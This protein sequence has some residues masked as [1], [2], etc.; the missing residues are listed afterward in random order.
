MAPP[1][2]FGDELKFSRY[3]KIYPD[4]DRPGSYLLYSTK[5]GSLIRLTE[6]LLADAREDS[7]CDEHCQTLSRLGMLVNDP[8][9]ELAEMND[10]VR[11]ANSRSTVFKGTIV[12]NLKCNLACTYCYEDG[13]RGDLEM[14]ASTADALVAWVRREHLEQGRDVELQFYGGEPLLSRPLIHRIAAPLRD[15]AAGLGRKF[16]TS[17]TSNGTLLTRDV[18]KELLPYN[19]TKANLTLDGPRETHDTQRP[20]ISG[21]GSFDTIVANIREIHDLVKIDLGGNCTPDNYRVFPELLGHLRREGITPEML[22]LVQ[23]FPVTPKSGAGADIASG[24]VSSSEPWLMEAI[25]YLHREIIRQG[26]R[27]AKPTMAACVVEFDHDLVVNYDGSFYKCAAFMGWPELSVG[28]LSE[29]VN[30]YAASHKLLYWQN[31][32]CLACPY[33]PLC[34]GGCRLN[35]LLKHGAIDRVDCRREFYDATLEQIVCHGL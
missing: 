18:V 12:L 19:F 35:P 13:F 28:S 32:E 3:L 20:F 31:D 29:G 27:T 34:F 21:R 22:G 4:S 15:A 23:F 26:Y 11:R 30:D 8:A 16:S 9:E 17:M 24:C 1:Y 10:L 7:L 5:R 6:A 2:F 33:L 25:P 14:S